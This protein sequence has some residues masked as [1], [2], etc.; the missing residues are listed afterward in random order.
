MNDDQTTPVTVSAL[1]AELVGWPDDAP[2]TI[3]VPDRAQS[4]I[5]AIL[6]IVGAG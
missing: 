1:R 2:L 6:P 5:A 4:S 3:T